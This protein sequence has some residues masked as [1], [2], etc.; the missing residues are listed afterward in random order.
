MQRET[1]A[2]LP[3]RS[4]LSDTGPDESSLIAMAMASSRGEKKNSARAE[5][6]VWKHA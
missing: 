4:E 2:F 5:K 6:T 1:V 3:M